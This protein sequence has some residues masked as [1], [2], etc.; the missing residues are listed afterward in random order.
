[1]RTS[2]GTGRPAIVFTDGDAGRPNAACDA[3]MCLLESR[4]LGSLSYVWGK[5][6]GKKK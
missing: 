4:C 2:G 5:K 6:K 3:F 1:M